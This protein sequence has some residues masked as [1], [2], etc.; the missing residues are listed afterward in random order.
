[1][2][3]DF[4]FAASGCKRDILSQLK[5]IDTRGSLLEGRIR[6]LLVDAIV[7]DL[8]APAGLSD[9]YIV[10]VNGHSGNASAPLT[11]NLRVQSRYTPRIDQL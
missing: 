8:D 11:I 2:S 10:N 3:T 5:N 9:H 1:M 6:D 4:Y 7:A